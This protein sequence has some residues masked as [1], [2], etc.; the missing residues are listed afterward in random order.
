MVEVLLTTLLVSISALIGVLITY[1]TRP[2]LK[3]YG[4]NINVMRTI[5]IAITVFSVVSFVFVNI[6]SVIGVV[7]GLLFC[8]VLRKDKDALHDW[9]WLGVVLGS[10]FA[11]SREA[12]IVVAIS[13]SLNNMIYASYANIPYVLKKVSGSKE[14]VIEQVVF[15]VSSLT[16]YMVLSLLGPTSASIVAY[17]A[18]LTFAGTFI[19]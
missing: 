15:I 19:K 1:F 12:G 14:R 11:V 10:S 16:A 5:L 8:Y 3:V 18:V 17:T 6:M 13:M 2:E 7:L 4:K 9:F